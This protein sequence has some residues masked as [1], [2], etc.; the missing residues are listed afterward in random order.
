M[1]A[2][3]HERSSGP[4]AAVKTRS[5]LSASAR[6][7]RRAVAE[8]LVRAEAHEHG[9]AEEAVVGLLEEAHLAHDPRLDPRVRAPARDGPA[10]RRAGEPPLPEQLARGAECAGIEPGAHPAGVDE[11]A[12]VARG[13]V[14]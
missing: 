11:R 3:L 13:E 14:K 1:F 8:E 2:P 12:S 9:M 7:G 5:G 10:A 6:R 4:R